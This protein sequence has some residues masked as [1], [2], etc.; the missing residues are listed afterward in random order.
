VVDD[1]VDDDADAPVGR[2][3]DHLREV[4]R[5]AQPAVDP[6]EVGDVVAVVALAAR[7]ERH[8]PHARDP[9]AGEVVEPVRQPGRS[10]QP[11][12]SASRNVSTSRQ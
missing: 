4:A 8:E 7:V 9:D 10:P 6:V 12:P 3:P 1:E 5:R 2:R 11:S